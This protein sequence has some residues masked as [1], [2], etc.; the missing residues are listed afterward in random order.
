MIQLG[1]NARRDPILSLASMFASGILREVAPIGPTERLRVL[2]EK[3]DRLYPGMGDQAMNKFEELH[4][5]GRSSDQALFDGVRLALANRLAEHSVEVASAVGLGVNMDN[6]TQGM[7]LATGAAAT[8]GGWLNGA[9]KDP[10]ASTTINTAAGAG[11]NIMGCNAGALDAQ[12]RI[13]EANARAAEAGASAANR[14]PAASSNKTLLYVGIGG[15]VLLVGVLGV[16][17]MKK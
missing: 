14:A 4:K 3:L 17:V 8:A 16:M 12:A 7:C 5:K 1:N 15:G 13:A 11:A 2:R 9:F 10:T 6:V